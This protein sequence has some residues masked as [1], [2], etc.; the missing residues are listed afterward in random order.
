MLV[1]QEEGFDCEIFSDSNGNVTGCIW[2]TAKLRDNFD[3]FGYFISIDTIK[4]GINN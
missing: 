4:L 3:Q 1:Y 2:K